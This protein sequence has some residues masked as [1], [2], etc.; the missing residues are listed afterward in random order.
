[1]QALGRERCLVAPAIP[2]LGRR[3]ERGH[4]VGWGIEQP[5][6]IRDAFASL[7]AQASI[8]DTVTDEE[9]DA[10]A[11]LAHAQDALF[12]GARGLAAALARLVCPRARLP[13]SFTGSPP[14]AFVIGSRD[15][16]TV[17]QVAYLRRQ[18]PEI[19]VLEAPDGS[20]KAHAPDLTTDRILLVTP[21]LVSDVPNAVMRRFVEQAIPRLNG[22]KTVIVAGGETA[23]ELL[24]GFG[25]DT[26]TVHN[27]ILPGIVW[28]DLQ[29]PA[30]GALSFVTKSGGFGIP[31]AFY[32]I[33]QVMRGT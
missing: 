6:S 4:A 23:Q 19:G 13:M 30:F 20:F 16:I 11:A 22:A 18:L 5:I 3:V 14:N 10:A 1:M 28:S 32:D 33:Y 21:G 31:S 15:P 7:A 2:N 8:P 24:A 25:A 29:T 26:L 12:V 27:E 9:L 17:G